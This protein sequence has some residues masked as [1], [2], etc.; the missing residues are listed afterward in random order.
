[1]PE[2][3]KKLGSRLAADYRIFRVLREPYIS[4]RTGSEL[5]G[6][7]LECADWCNV[8]AY[9][10]DQRCI[11]I[12]Q[13]RFGT[14]EVTVEIPGGIIDPGEDPFSAAKRELREETGFEA[15]RWTALGSIAPNPAFQRNRM[16]TFFAEGCRLA[17]DLQQDEL[18]DIEVQLVP[19]A[20]ID[21]MLA[22]GELDHALVA[23]AFQKVALMHKG[24]PSR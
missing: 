20:E 15:A 13:Y 18:E 2:H 4:P 17:G 1:M 8:V 10:E 22:R 5:D 19:I 6:V 16:Y 11:L 21:G 14:N 3:W 12:K 7:I 9:T 23:I 24:I